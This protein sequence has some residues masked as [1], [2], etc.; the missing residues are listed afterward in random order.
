MLEG[1]S[2]QQYNQ[3]LSDFP[4]GILGEKHREMTARIQMPLSGRLGFATTHPREQGFF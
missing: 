3:L 1:E 2:T 4:R